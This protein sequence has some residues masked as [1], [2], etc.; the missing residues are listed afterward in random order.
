MALTKVSYSMITGSPVNILDFGAVGDGTTDDTAA[1]QAAIATGNPIYFPKPLAYYNVTSSIVITAPFIAGLYKVFNSSLYIKFG[2]KSVVEV[3]P[4]WWGAVPVADGAPILS[5]AAIQAAIDSTTLLN[6]STAFNEGTTLRVP[7]KFSM[8]VYYTDNLTISHPIRWLGSGMENTLIKSVNTNTN[9]IT[10]TSVNPVEFYD[11]SFGVQD[12]LGPMTAGSFLSFD[13][14]SYSNQYSKIIRVAFNNGYNF[15]NTV[16]AM[17]IDIDSCYFNRYTGNAINI[18]NGL[19]PD[20]GDSSI[21][22]CTFN[23]GSGTAVYQVNSGGLRITNNK[24]LGGNY[25]YYG[26]YSGGF[27]ARTGQLIISN[28]SFDQCFIAN[29]AFAKSTDT[30]FTGV[31]ITN[32]IIIASAGKYGIL[33]NA[34]GGSTFLYQMLIGNNLFYLRNTAVG[35]HLASCDGVSITPNRFWCDGGDT[36]TGIIFSNGGPYSNISVHGQNYQGTITQTSGSQTNVT[37]LTGVYKTYAGNPNSNVQMN[38]I[39]EELLDTTNNK[40]YKAFGLTNTQWAAL[41]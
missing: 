21:T 13:P 22:N 40:W 18:G 12:G 37:F 20:G 30:V 4:E 8:G 38:Y 16:D 3:Y 36:A 5:T 7:I 15:I 35:I 39:G 25:S 31:S 2:L 32:N 24:F 33:V 19:L 9:L 17:F 1:I 10:I 34:Y 29:I 23:N 41:N 28:N 11:L 26:N 27:A 6:A 14:V